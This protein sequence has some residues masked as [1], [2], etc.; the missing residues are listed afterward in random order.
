MLHRKKISFQNELLLLCSVFSL[1]QSDDKYV[2]DIDNSHDDSDNN[3]H[4]DDDD[5]MALA[6]NT[7]QKI[8]NLHTIIEDHII[9]L[10]HRVTYAFNSRLAKYV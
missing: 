1:Y 2:D 4:D 3:N 9:R 6:H 10:Y 8:V 5:G 7:K